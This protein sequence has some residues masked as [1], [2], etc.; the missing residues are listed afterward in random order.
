MKVVF[1]SPTQAFGYVEVEGTVEDI[2][3]MERIYNKYAENKLDFKGNFTKF[4]TFTG[5]DILYDDSIH[6]YTDLDGNKLIS[7][8]AYAK[9]II[10][11]F[12]TDLL[13]GKVAKKYSVPQDKVK[14]MWS[15]SGEISSTFGTA[16]HLAMEQWFL[17]RHF[18]TE[19]EYHLPK[20][21]YLRSAVLSFP[22]KDE[23]IIPEAMISDVK[24][25]RCGQVDGL[26]EIGKNK[27]KILDYK[28]DSDIKKNIKK[29][30]IQLNF[31]RDILEQKGFEIGGMSLWNYTG[32]WDEVV[33]PVTEI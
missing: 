19:K 6:L 26:Q 31:Y 30:T 12:N 25:R 3:E 18:G 24:R 28:S 27:Y 21:E 23:S 11:E 32:K 13:S 5:E 16:L 33:I 8:S 14:D 10:G 4:H 7:G 1:H 17:H 15:M 2:P 9:E 29:H 20:P 22:L